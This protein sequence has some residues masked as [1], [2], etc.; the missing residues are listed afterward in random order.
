MLDASNIT[1]DK[2]LGKVIKELGFISEQPDAGTRSSFLF[3]SA[4]ELLR[5][6]CQW[7]GWRQ[8]PSIKQQ[9][10]VSVESNQFHV[11][12]C[13]LENMR[14]VL[15]KTLGEQILEEDLHTAIIEA[16]TP[17]EIMKKVPLYRY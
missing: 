4:K 11:Y 16:A 8:N 13:D 17:E 9:V 1:D 3:G 14:F 15:W 12:W 7:I 2:I 10:I 6:P 5:I